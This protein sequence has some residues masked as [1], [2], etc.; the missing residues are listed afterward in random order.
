MRD[1]FG[2]RGPEAAR[3]A[4]GGKDADYRLWHA[5]PAAR[6]GQ[7]RLVSRALPIDVD[8]DRPGVSLMLPGEGA[9]HGN[10]HPP[11]GAGQRR[12][13]N[14]QPRKW[15]LG[16]SRR[17]GAGHARCHPVRSQGGD[18]RHREGRAGLQVRRP[19]RPRQSGDRSRPARARAQPQERLRQQRSRLF[20][21]SHRCGC[22][23]GAGS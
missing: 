22:R 6:A 15:G 23:G 2:G 17:P 4:L 19:D 11:R 8:P 20:R 18:P 3:A 7:S 16:R 10:T 5:K 13:C 12:G 14:T 21:R 9:R 1:F